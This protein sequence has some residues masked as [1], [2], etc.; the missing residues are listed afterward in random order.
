MPKLPPKWMDNAFKGLSK[1]YPKDEHIDEDAMLGAA[2]AMAD[3]NIMRELE[4]Q[5]FKIGV[6]LFDELPKNIRHESVKQ[7][8]YRP[9]DHVEVRSILDRDAMREHVRIRNHRTGENIQFPIE[10]LHKEIQRERELDRE[11]RYRDYFYTPNPNAQQLLQ[12]MKAALIGDWGVKPL[13]PRAQQYLQN[14]LQDLV[15]NVPPPPPPSPDY[16]PEPERFVDMILIIAG[17]YEEAH[18]YVTSQLGVPR[19]AWHYVRDYKDMAKFGSCS[20]HIVGSARARDDFEA[21]QG[22][23]L[24]YNHQVLDLEADEGVEE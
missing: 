1:E 8:R 16:I 22:L 2:L 3:A 7:L 6:A 10:F 13:E 20:V 17:T 23:F 15:A 19:H 12:D 5:E 9:G 14:K 21:I 4:G 24:I 18:E 11:Q